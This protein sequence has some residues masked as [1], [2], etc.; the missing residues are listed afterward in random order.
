[1]ALNQIDFKFNGVDLHA[2]LIPNR[3]VMGDSVYQISWKD[4]R[5]MTTT[6]ASPQTPI[7]KVIE[8]WKENGF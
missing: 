8:D 5:L 2:A 1:M 3:R 6:L 4:G 7:E